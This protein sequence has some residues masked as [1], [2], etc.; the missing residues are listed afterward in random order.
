MVLVGNLNLNK[1]LGVMSMKDRYDEFKIWVLQNHSDG[2]I[3]KGIFDAFE[4]S[5]KNS[6][7]IEIDLVDVFK[8]LAEIG[9]T[10]VINEF[11]E[12]YQVDKQEY[13]KWWD[14]IP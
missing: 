1:K 8:L 3:I 9:S 10:V 14:S 5:Y 4:K 11:C 12:K 6:K 2:W 13:N 7:K